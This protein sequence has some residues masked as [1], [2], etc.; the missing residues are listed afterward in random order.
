MQGWDVRT[1]LTEIIGDVYQSHVVAQ[2]IGQSVEIFNRCMG[3]TRTGFMND[4]C[5]ITQPVNVFLLE[6]GVAGV[7]KHHIA[8]GYLQAHRRDR[9]LCV[10]T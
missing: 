8:I 9:M 6:G 3:G 7:S 10:S 2:F 4:E 5:C 1:G